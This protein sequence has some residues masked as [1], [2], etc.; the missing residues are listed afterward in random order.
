MNVFKHVRMVKSTVSW[1]EAKNGKE[2]SVKLIYEKDERN[3]KYAS[4]DTKWDVAQSLKLKN[5]LMQLH[6]RKKYLN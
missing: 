5:E 2:P 6:K 4:V 3:P 1:D